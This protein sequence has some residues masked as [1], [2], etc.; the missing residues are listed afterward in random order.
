[1]H[2]PSRMQA[3]SWD[4]TLVATV[5]LSAGLRRFAGGVERIEVE[6]ASVRDL[7]DALDRLFPGIGEQL[8]GGTAV[9]IDGEIISEPLLEPIPP[10]SEVHFLPS[11]SGGSSGPAGPRMA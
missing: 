6:A 8:R 10:G 2:R 11:I 4:G 7:I 5:F 9:A 3:N 1:M